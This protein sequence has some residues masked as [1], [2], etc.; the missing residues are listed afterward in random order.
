MTE[1][2]V[3]GLMA[4]LLAG[5]AL[6][7]AT[8]GF[9]QDNAAAAAP[10]VVEKAALV[11]I[12]PPKTDI[13]RIIKASLQTAYYD[14]EPNTRAYTQAQKLYFFYGGRGF[15]P[16]WLSTDGSGATTF[17]PNAT[18][19]IAL[20]KRAELEGLRPSDYLSTDLD[21][22]AAGTDPAK[23]AALETDFSA[24]ALRYAQDS[25]GGRINPTAVNVLLTIAPQR[26]AAADTQTKLAAAD[27]PAKFL[28][29]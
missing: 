1:S 13:A 6:M 23:L 25:Y 20:F 17:S 7:A 2:A 22:S 12:A 9:A 29:G 4:V 8:P 15:E 5:V 10:A 18:K 3:R 24:A 26:L 11:V 21:P 28:T 16:I 14:A 19:V 27:D